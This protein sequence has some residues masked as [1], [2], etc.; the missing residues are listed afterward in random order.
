MEP[1][2]RL[3]VWYKNQCD[4][5]WEHS[6]GIKIE[7]LDNPGWSLT[8]DLLSTSLED[9]VDFAEQQQISEF[10]WYHI[11]IDD[12][13]YIAYG[14]PSKLNFLIS[15][16]LD[17]I[18]AK[19]THSDFEYEI[20][21]PLF[22]APTDVWTK[23]YAIMK[24]EFE[25]ELIRISPPDSNTMLSKTLD[26][27]ETWIQD[28]DKFELKNKIGDIVET[29]LVETFQGNHLGVKKTTSRK[30]YKNLSWKLKKLVLAHLSSNS[31]P[32]PFI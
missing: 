30:R 29:E 26:S 32:F 10:D 28:F 27:V 31:C 4:G 12:V 6:Y 17:Q 8:I 20:L 5:D 16:F 14:D 1:I 22:G 21:V 25:F 2:E 15:Y 7:T 3:Q 24:N 18:V 23:G 9:V 13:K 19:C 11:K